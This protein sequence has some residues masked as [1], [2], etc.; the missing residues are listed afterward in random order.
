M[1]VFHLSSLVQFWI[2]FSPF[3]FSWNHT[4]SLY[5]TIFQKQTATNYNYTPLFFYFVWYCRV[6]SFFFEPWQHCST[7]FYY[8]RHPLYIYPP[9]TPGPPILLARLPPF[10][11]PSIQLLTLFLDNTTNVPYIYMQQVKKKKILH[12][13]GQPKHTTYKKVT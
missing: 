5:S 13:F 2:I 6:A 12:Y 11:P 10:C 4:Q 8:V 3:F 7:F 9:L 1:S